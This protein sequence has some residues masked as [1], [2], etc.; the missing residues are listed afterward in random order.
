M[1]RAKSTE[2]LDH[3][4][5]NLLTVSE[6]AQFCRMSSRTL[7]RHLQAGV[8]PAKVK[9]GSLVFFRKQ[10]L[11]SWILSHETKREAP[12]AKRRRSTRA[13]QADAQ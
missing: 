12:T 9:L 2:S 5:L 11:V 1:E 7:Q 6:A 13:P 8:G 4:E 3:H 10:S